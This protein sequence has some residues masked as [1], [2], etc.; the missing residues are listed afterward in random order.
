MVQSHGEPPEPQ[1][2]PP[3]TTA[4]A[5]VTTVKPE[6]NA[7]PDLTDV[8][9]AAIRFTAYDLDARLTPASSSLAMR[10]RLTV[11]NVRTVP[12]KALALQVSS[13]LRWESVTLESGAARVKLPLAQHLLETDADHT[14]QVSEAVITLP[15]PLAPGASVR[16]DTFYSGTVAQNATR[17]Q[18]LGANDAAG[19]EADWDAIGAGGDGPGT[20]TALRGFG[21]VLWYP[22]SAPQLF[23]GQGAQLFEAA[24]RLRLANVATAVHLR[25][26]VDYLGDPPSA[27]YFCGRRRALTAASDNADAPVVSSP[28]V[29]TADFPESPLGFRTLS[30]F[31]IDSPETLLPEAGQSAPAAPPLAVESG[32]T[33]VFPLLVASSTDAAAVITDWLG[34]KPLSSL[35]I[36]DHAGQPFEDG[37]L[38]VAPLSALAGA[39]AAPALT[40]SLTH[41]WV[42]TGVPW[43]DE[44]LAQL[45]VLLAVERS[46]GREAAEAQL[47]ALVQPLALGDVAPKAA[48][49]APE[50][51]GIP[52]A[53][54]DSQPQAQALTEASSDIF[55]RRKA[56]AVWW[57][58]R[59]L[60]GEE[61]L[62][63][64]LQAWR[65]QP[66]SKEGAVA[67]TKGFE[68][69]L[70][71]VSGKDLRWF[72]DDW[73][74]RDVGLPD[75]T[76]AEVTPRELE[77]STGRKTG[78]LVAVTV[79]NDGAAAAD[80][81]VIVRASGLSATARIRVPGFGSVTQRVLVEAPPTEVIVNDGTTPEQRT[82]LHTK[83][84]VVR[85]K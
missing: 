54:L 40:H 42:Q 16:L 3:S 81:P 47:Q 28:G 38:L 23:L 37:P 21:D 49:A 57:M 26:A 79:R 43:M 84:V 55:Y 1:T 14:G 56:A 25:L 52:P 9:R 64:A 2:V 72:F 62:K 74:F 67:Q 8:E 41:A 75:L 48:T 45:M 59:D 77:S 11:R 29:A 33:A 51:V 53:S 58:L 70:E 27:A 65:V 36:L 18:R 50:G 20:S 60:A 78:W 24:G 66:A 73:V 19:K 32:K 5:A 44:G 80:V 22:V 68:A 82:S 76:I 6:E 35:A 13:S 71:K 39:D 46:R 34:P 61:P 10:A 85:A 83:D 15:E 7:V 69:L 17:L 63:L 4:G 31:V 30:L 12:L